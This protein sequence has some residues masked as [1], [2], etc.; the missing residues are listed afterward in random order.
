VPYFFKLNKGLN[1]KRDKAEKRVS[2]TM[3]LIKKNQRESLKDDLIVGIAG[4][5]VVVLI[6]VNALLTA[7]A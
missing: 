5:I 1:M 2:R 4:I 6:G 3:R 7:G